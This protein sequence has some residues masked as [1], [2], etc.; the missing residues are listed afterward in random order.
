MTYVVALAL[1]AQ[2]NSTYAETAF[3]II[4]SFMPKPYSQKTIVLGLTEEC[5]G[6][7]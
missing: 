3:N 6:K 2:I 1:V 4:M 5:G 7:E